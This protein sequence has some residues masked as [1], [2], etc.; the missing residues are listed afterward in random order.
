MKKLVIVAAFAAICSPAFAGG[1]SSSKQALNIGAVVNTGKGGLL[2]AVLGSNSNHGTTGVAAGVN[3]STGKGGVLGT[4]LG[5][6][7]GHGTT[8]LGVGVAVNTGKGGVLGLLTGSGSSSHHGG[9]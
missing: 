4:V 6:N 7:S 1:N 5:S 3:V 2:G 9:Y 8:G